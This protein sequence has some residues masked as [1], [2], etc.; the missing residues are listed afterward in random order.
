MKKE[1]I[2]LERV[3][4]AP[5]DQIWQAITNKDKMKQ[6]YFDI[7]KFEATTGFEF[8]F[9]GGKDEKKYL[10]LCK[11]TEVVPGKKLSYSWR[12]ED[13]PGESLLTFELFPEGD[14]TRMKLTHSGLDSFPAD[15]PDFAK[16]SFEAGWNYILGMS[17]KNFLEK[18]L[19]VPN[20]NV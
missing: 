20:G 11:I 16:E 8:Q 1:P 15:N 19:A 5:I 14:A 6:W 10:H 17:L 18:S 13:Y 7:D 9:Y 2:V 4:Q 12:Y 3:F